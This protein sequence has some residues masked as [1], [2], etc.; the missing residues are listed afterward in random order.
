[1]SMLF[2]ELC[3]KN[4]EVFDLQ[5]DNLAEK[6]QMLGLDDSLVTPSYVINT[7]SL[8]EKIK[9]SMENNPEL[10]Y[11]KDNEAFLKNIMTEISMII[12]RS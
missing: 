8:Q 11:H 6:F 10:N 9:K 7:S 1:M 12:R 3:Y 4:K 2:K 5:F